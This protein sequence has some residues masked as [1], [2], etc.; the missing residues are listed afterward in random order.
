MPKPRFVTVTNDV[1]VL[2]SGS[3]WLPAIIYGIMFAPVLWLIIHNSFPVILWV[4]LIWVVQAIFRQFNW[5][6]YPYDLKR[7]DPRKTVISNVLL[8]PLL[9]VMF[10]FIFAPEQTSTPLTAATSVGLG[11]IF[12]FITKYFSPWMYKEPRSEHFPAMKAEL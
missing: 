6:G 10:F 8:I 11:V 2:R 5:F 12:M 7:T 4:V 3:P 1:K 9:L